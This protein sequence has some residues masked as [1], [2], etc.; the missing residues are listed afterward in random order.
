MRYLLKSW[1]AEEQTQNTENLMKK[2]P[3]DLIGKHRLAHFFSNCWK[4]AQ[5][6]IYLEVI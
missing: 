3:S 5:L 4:P 2:S 1:A 6:F